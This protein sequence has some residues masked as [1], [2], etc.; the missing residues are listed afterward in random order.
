MPNLDLE[1]RG[2]VLCSENKDA[3]QLRGYREVDLRLWLRICGLLFFC[4]A[5]HML[6]IMTKHIFLSVNKYTRSL[7]VN[8]YTSISRKENDT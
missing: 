8:T 1:S 7:S 6:Y 3:D 5:A 2:N 4:G